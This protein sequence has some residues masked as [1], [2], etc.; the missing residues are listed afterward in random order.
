MLEKSFM[1]V[2]EVAQELQISKSKAYQVVKAMNDEMKE[3]GYLTISGR[4]NT[5]FFKKKVC[6][7][8]IKKGRE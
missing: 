7:D 1:T 3:K 2:E 4:I 8:E 6:Y 5:A